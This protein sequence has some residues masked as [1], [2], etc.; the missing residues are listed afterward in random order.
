MWTNSRIRTWWIASAS[1]LRNSVTHRHLWQQHATER[2]RRWLEPQ[3][4]ALWQFVSV[5]R[6]LR[7][8]VRRHLRLVSVLRSTS[9]SRACASAGFGRMEVAHASSL[10]VSASRRIQDWKSLTSRTRRSDIWAAAQH[11]T[12]RSLRSAGVAMRGSGAFVWCSVCRKETRRAV[13][14]PQH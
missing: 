13:S 12:C 8:L 3:R 14:K 9:S 2:P 5:L 4:L 1:R 11:G 6:A 10:N 7:H